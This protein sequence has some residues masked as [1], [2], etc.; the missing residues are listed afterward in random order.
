[1]W[2]C[3]D[4]ISFLLAATRQRL[5][6]G[7]QVFRQRADLNGFVP[8]NAWTEGGDIAQDEAN[9]ARRD[10]NCRSH[11]HYSGAAEYRPCPERPAHRPAQVA[12]CALVARPDGA[13]AQGFPI[14]RSRHDEAGAAASLPLLSQEAGLG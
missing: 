3:S 6:L 8:S 10:W 12:L 1:S 13:A 4:R 14:D 2:D 9:P 5:T 7:S 11:H